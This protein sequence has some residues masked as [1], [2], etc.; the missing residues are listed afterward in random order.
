MPLSQDNHIMV[1]ALAPDRSDQP[2]SKA[3]LPRGCWCNWLV[4][5]A[6]GAQSACDDSAIDLIPITDE[7]ARGVIPRECLD[8]L[9]RN[10]FCRWVFCHVD[11][12]QVSTVQSDDDQGI[13]QVETDS[14][15]NE[16]VHGGNVR[17]VVTQKG[18]PSLTGRSPSLDHVLGDA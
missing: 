11:P 7:V 1:H 3:V 12:D 6:H 9:A 8:Y 2:F 10:P 13:E 15:D 5:N 14:R 16:Q 18:A 4:P 17:R